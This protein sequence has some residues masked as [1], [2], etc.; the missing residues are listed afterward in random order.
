MG[1][2][3]TER[4]ME[5]GTGCGRGKS[6]AG[7][8][9]WGFV[10]VGGVGFGGIRGGVRWQLDA[11]VRSTLDRRIRFS[12]H[13]HRHSR[14]HAR[15]S[16]RY[17]LARLNVYMCL[18]NTTCPF[19]S[20]SFA[21]GSSSSPIRARVRTHTSFSR[22]PRA[23]LSLSLF[24][25]VFVPL[26]ARWSL[27]RVRALAVTLCSFVSVS[28]S[29][30]SEVSDTDARSRIA[31]FVYTRTLFV[32]WQ[33]G[34]GSESR[35]HDR[36]GFTRE[37]FVRRWTQDTWSPNVTLP[38]SHVSVSE[39]SRGV[40]DGGRMRGNYSTF[41]SNNGVNTVDTNRGKLQYRETFS[42][43]EEYIEYLVVLMC[44]TR[45]LFANCILIDG[46]NVLDENECQPL[47]SN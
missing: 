31:S 45:V 7:V 30:E 15:V 42:S 25:S 21:L 3:R 23:T 1:E 40:S 46:L 19:F 4:R 14:T 9:G 22:P 33:F 20:F 16:P 24:S 26:A 29:A 18:C 36:R 11:L 38:S 6:E 41:A 10:T 28:T 35:G 17:T 5:E 27:A 43:F 34:G 12:A 44:F 13:I 2:R 47:F 39:E 8:M 37:T 32:R